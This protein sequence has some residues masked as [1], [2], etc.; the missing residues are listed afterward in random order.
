SPTTSIFPYTTLFRSKELQHIR[1]IDITHPDD[2]AFDL[3]VRSDLV[4]GKKNYQTFLKRYLHKGNYY[5]WCSIT[6]SLVRDNWKN[7]QYFRSEEHT[8]ELQSREN[9]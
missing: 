5:V 7:P 2:K 1:S 6:I 3:S 9:L 4:Q 8:S